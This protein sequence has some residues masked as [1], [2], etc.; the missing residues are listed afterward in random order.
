ME[1]WQQKLQLLA[2]WWQTPAG[3]SLLQIEKNYLGEILQSLFG[4]QLVLIA[5]ESYA[6]LSSLSRTSH[7]LRIDPLKDALQQLPSD[8]DAIVLPHTLSYMP[9][10]ADWI[11]TLHHQLEDHGKL[12]ITGYRYASLLGV[13]KFLLQSAVQAIPSKINSLSKIRQQL[14]KNDFVLERKENIAA[15]WTRKRLTL[16]NQALRTSVLGN[17]SCIVASKKLA[18]IKSFEPKWTKGATA[19]QATSLNSVAGKSN[20][21]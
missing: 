21:S 9:E 12:I 13:Q 2:N 4:F 17:I 5:D 19:R 14:I 18:T 1:Y 11:M 6:S 20:D 16:T 3:Q 8:V 15:V 7:V 10:L